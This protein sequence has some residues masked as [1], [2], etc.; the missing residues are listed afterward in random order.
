VNIERESRLSGRTYDKGLLI[1]EGYL[2]GMYSG[3]LPL[4]LSASLA[5]EQSYGG[6]DG[7]SASAAELIAL[8]SAIARLPLRQ[9]VA[10][11]GSIDQLGN[12]QPI[13]GVN[14]K[15]E[16]FFAVCS[17]LGLTGNQGVCIPAA[18]VRNLVLRGEV[19][20]A[21]R[22]GKFHLWPLR[23][24]DEGIALLTGVAAGK[25]D[26]PLTVHGRVLARLREMERQMRPH[27]SPGR[28]RVAVASETPPAPPDPKPS[29]PG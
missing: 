16:G 7:D 4:A 11:T 9:D 3:E 28:D 26:Q 23:S 24:I 25:I 10:I 8:L 22:E 27:T 12:I 15:V 19:I 14:E 29:L 1:L 6:V 13:G 21:V 2:R 17:R 18:N 20:D 5:M